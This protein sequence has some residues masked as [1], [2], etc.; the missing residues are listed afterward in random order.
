MNGEVC[1]LG[2]GRA[3]VTIIRG[4]LPTWGKHFRCFARP[5]SLSELNACEGFSAPSI[6]PLHTLA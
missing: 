4:D 3:T 5:S 2:G 6:L 1:K